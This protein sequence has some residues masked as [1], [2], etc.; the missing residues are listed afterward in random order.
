[1]LHYNAEPDLDLL[2]TGLPEGWAA[3]RDA[4]SGDVYYG[5]KQTQ[6]RCATWMSNAMR[7]AT[8][9]WIKQARCLVHT[10]MLTHIGIYVGADDK[11]LAP[12]WQHF[13]EVHKRCAG[14]AHHRSNG[15]Q[16]GC[17]RS[18]CSCQ[19]MLLSPDRQQYALTRPSGVRWLATSVASCDSVSSSK[20]AGLPFDQLRCY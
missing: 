10:T 9:Q 1:M 8:L 7:A 12:S 5:N 15:T 2:S 18:S 13:S 14:Q 6:V 4:A 19:V 11:V 17:V 3:M 20:D 16:T